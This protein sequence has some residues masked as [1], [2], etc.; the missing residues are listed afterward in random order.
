[1]GNSLSFTG[2]PGSGKSTIVDL[3]LRLVKEHKGRVV[4]GNVNVDKFDELSWRSKIGYVSQE[5]MLF[6]DTVEENIRLGNY[7]AS[8][9]EIEHAARIAGVHEFILTLPNGY[10]TLVGKG[11]KHFLGSKQR[12]SIARAL[13]RNP[14][15]LLLDEVTS[16]LDSETEKLFVKNLLTW[17][18]DKKTIVLITHNKSLLKFADDIFLIQNGIVKVRTNINKSI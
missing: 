18:N 8:I 3:I 17:K 10:Q 11:E 6:N 13:V 14:D 4:I 2:L 5:V 1:M 9:S 15:L 7:K 12:I 16:A